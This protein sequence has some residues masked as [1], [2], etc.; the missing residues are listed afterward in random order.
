MGVGPKIWTLLVIG[1]LGCASKAEA[2]TLRFEFTGRLVDLSECGDDPPG[3]SCGA[4]V[5]EFEGRF[6]L[7][8]SSINVTE[9][10]WG[11]IDETGETALLVFG[12]QGG[13]SNLRIG[14]AAFGDVDGVDGAGQ[15]AAQLL[16][17]TTYENYFDLALQNGYWL[18]IV[19]FLARPAIAS[20]GGNGVA[21]ELARLYASGV[22]GGVLLMG[23]DA[24]TLF[25]GDHLR[26][27]V[28]EVPEPDTLALLVVALA[29][30]GISRRRT[31]M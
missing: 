18:S 23:T 27:N 29:C 9:E 3:P 8:F 13:F 4:P 2:T 25:G 24:G 19:D 12:F 11:P 26:W 16:G 21:D 10:G 6:D 17:T 31:M 1:V 15:G 5:G 14:A 28:L 22:F 7:D 20:D 30:A